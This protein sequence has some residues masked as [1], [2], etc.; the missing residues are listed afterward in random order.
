MDPDPGAGKPA[1][2]PFSSYSR[3]LVRAASARKD[4]FVGIDFCENNTVDAMKQYCTMSNEKQNNTSGDNTHNTRGVNTG[5]LGGGNNSIATAGTGDRQ[6]HQAEQDLDPSH[7]DRESG[8]ALELSD[9]EQQLL[10]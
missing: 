8:Q 1:T 10:D 5:S 4:R 9:E 6:H 2:S 7:L 3:R